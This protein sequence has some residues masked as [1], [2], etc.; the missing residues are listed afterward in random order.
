MSLF[1]PFLAG[2]ISCY[3]L[4]KDFATL[5]VNVGNMSHLLRR[6]LCRFDI[7]LKRYI[8]CVGACNYDVLTSCTWNAYTFIHCVY[9]M[10]RWVLLYGLEGLSLERCQ[11]TEPCTVEHPRFIPI[12]RSTRSVLQRRRLMHLCCVAICWLPPP[13]PPL[14]A[15]YVP[16][17]TRFVAV[18]EIG[19][20]WRCTGK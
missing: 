20:H 7:F 17:E 6:M 1:P 14:T 4:N 18:R 11:N 12:Q 15:W 16:A 3:F 13:T 8:W 9:L 19:Q 10:C 2:G 5:V